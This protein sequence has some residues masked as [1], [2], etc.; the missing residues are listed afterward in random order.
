MSARWGGTVS[1]WWIDGCY[2]A[3]KM[4]RHPDGPNFRSFAAALKAGNPDAQVA[5][6]PGVL[7]PIVTHT[8]CDDYTAGES[9][10]MVTPNRYHVFDRFVNGA[11]FHVLSYLGDYWCHGEPRY[12]D[13]LAASYIRYINGFDGAVTG[14]CRSARRPHTG[15]V[16]AATRGNRKIGEGR[17]ENMKGRTM[18]GWRH[19][20]EGEFTLIELLVV[21]AIIAI[22]A[23]LL[24]PALK[25]ARSTAVRISCAGNLKQIGLACVSY[26]SDTGGGWLPEGAGDIGAYASGSG[27]GGSQRFPTGMKFSAGP[28]YSVKMNNAKTALEDGGYLPANCKALLCPSLKPGTSTYTYFYAAHYATQNSGLWNPNDSS[29]KFRSTYSVLDDQISDALIATDLTIPVGGTNYVDGRVA[30]DDVA[31]IKGL[32][33]LHGDGHVR[34]HAL[35]DCFLTGYTPQAG[36]YLPQVSKRP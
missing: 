34:W 20:R 26:A 4:Y 30:H 10:V 25:V 14:M 23:S 24:L 29:Y 32:N 27:F 17:G 19:R 35:G 3:D 15:G 6:N 1:G 13:E 2:Y 33:A 11:Q 5:F 9:N 22:L 12:P 28:W 16:S 7:V 21:I 18:S 36:I 8:E 31:A